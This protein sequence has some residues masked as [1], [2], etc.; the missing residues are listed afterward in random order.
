MRREEADKFANGES[1]TLDGSL[2]GDAQ[3][4]FQSPAGRSAID[5]EGRDEAAQRSSPAHAVAALV[6]VTSTGAFAWCG[7]ET[8]YGDGCY[9]AYSASGE[10][11]G[12]ERHGDF[13]RHGFDRIEH[14]GFER[15]P[16]GVSTSN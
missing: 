14:R 13:E 1:E 5:H 15:W 9:G 16:V 11:S 3:E 4:R 10:D 6:A 8:G 12:F 2:R 7:G